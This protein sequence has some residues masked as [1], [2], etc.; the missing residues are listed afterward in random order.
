MHTQ[1]CVLRLHSTRLF[2][3]HTLS[4]GHSP[5]KGQ[6][7]RQLDSTLHS[8]TDSRCPTCHLK[9]KLIDATYDFTCY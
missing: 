5:L 7:F 4:Q 9:E 8:W 6:P 3:H 1:V 2:I